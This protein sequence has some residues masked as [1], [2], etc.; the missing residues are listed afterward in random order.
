[1]KLIHVFGFD[2]LFL[3][4]RLSTSL[5]TSLSAGLAVGFLR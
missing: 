1:M 5:A 4:P 3:D 2:V